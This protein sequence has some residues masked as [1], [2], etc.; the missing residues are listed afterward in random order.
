MLIGRVFGVLVI[1]GYHE[2][3]SARKGYVIVIR[4]DSRA[5]FRPFL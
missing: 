1:S 2:L 3:L 4:G 5:D